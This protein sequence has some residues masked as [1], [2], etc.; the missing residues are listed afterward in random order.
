MCA[1]TLTLSMFTLAG[2]ER[3]AEATGRQPGTNDPDTT[4]ERSGANPDRPSTEGATT[5]GSIEPRTFVEH[6]ASGGMFEVE[7]AK[8]ALQKD[9]REPVRELAQRIQTDHQKANQELKQIA[10]EMNLKVPE[11]MN[12]EHQR[13]LSK[14]QGASGDSFERTFLELQQQA[15]RE[16]IELFERAKS[17]LPDSKLATFAGNKL[18][19]L[20]EHLEM[21]RNRQG[22]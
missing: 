3:D 18:P 12:A 16:A 11:Q 21:A 19:T 15:H 22:G 1:A 10:Q 7:S 13:M 6:A 4:H 9:L 17:G 8:L 2:C 5:K 14:L 20:R